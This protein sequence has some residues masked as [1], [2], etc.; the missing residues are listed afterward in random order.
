MKKFNAGWIGDCVAF[1]GGTVF[2]GL[3]A[4]LAPSRVNI[5][6]T[7]KSIATNSGYHDAVKAIMNSDMWDSYKEDAMKLLK[8]D[9]DAA[10]YESAISIIESDSWDSYKIDMLKLLNK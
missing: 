1:I 2:L 3:M 6:V 8:R 10:Y 4:A 5:H 9:E 7:E